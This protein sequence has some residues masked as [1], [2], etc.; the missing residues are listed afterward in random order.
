M[1]KTKRRRR[2]YV[3]FLSTIIMHIMCHHNL[4][5]FKDYIKVSKYNII[6]ILL[7]LFI[8]ILYNPYNL[9]L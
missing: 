6:N 5:T 7:Y 1:T 2:N 8:N 9:I 3:G 4:S